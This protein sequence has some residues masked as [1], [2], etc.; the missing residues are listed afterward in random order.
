MSSQNLETEAV[1]LEIGGQARSRTPWL[2]SANEKGIHRIERGCRG[3][4]GREGRCVGFYGWKVWLSSSLHPEGCYRGS[5]RLF[6][7]EWEVVLVGFLFI[8][9]VSHFEME[10]I[11]GFVEGWFAGAGYQHFERV[12][13]H[14][15][16]P[17][18]KH[19]GLAKRKR[20]R[21][22]TQAWHTEQISF[23]GND[24]PVSFSAFAHVP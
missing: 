12:C 22:D 16:C 15:T 7:C 19:D 9:V 8:D 24:L 11:V 1:V 18:G 14:P 4:K 6:E 3:E 17:R 5:E 21:A 20:N 13:A 10:G 23:S 2:L